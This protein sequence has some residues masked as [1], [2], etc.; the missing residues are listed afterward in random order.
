M[1]VDTDPP[2]DGY[3]PDAKHL[4]R[5]QVVPA[6]LVDGIYY[7]PMPHLVERKNDPGWNPSHLPQ[8]RGRP[9]TSSRCTTLLFFGVRC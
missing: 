9:K 5:E 4:R 8:E 6:T 7:R 1:A 3:L 2:I